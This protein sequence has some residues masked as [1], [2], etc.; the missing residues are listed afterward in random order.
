MSYVKFPYQPVTESLSM[1]YV[2][3]RLRF[4]AAAVDAW[5]LVD[6]GAEVN[7]MPHSVGVRLGLNWSDF[8]VGPVLG[9][10]AFGET[11]VVDIDLSIGSV[12]RVPLTFCW[13]NH[14]RVKLLLGH[15]NFFEEF[16][17][18]F[19]TKNRELS[20]LKHAGPS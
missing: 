1:P 12:S 8:S 6:T 18:F 15:Q 9:G 7:V 20:I 13:A 16:N 2:R 19:D 10:N 3:V 14:D 11:R 17:A 5:A 4:G